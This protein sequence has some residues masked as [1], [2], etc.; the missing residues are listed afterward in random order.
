[1]LAASA[2]SP[3]SAGVQQLHVGVHER[4]HRRLHQ[5]EA[6]VASGAEAAVAVERDHLRCRARR[7]SSAP[8]SLE[9]LSTT[10]SAGARIEVALDRVEQALQVRRGV[11][12]HGDDRERGH[13]GRLGQDRPRLARR[14]L[15]RQLR[16]RLAAGR[17][18]PLAQAGLALQAEQRVGERAGVAGRHPQRAR[19]RAS[20]RTREVRHHRRRAAG[21]RLDRR[22]AEALVARHARQR[23]R[24]R[25]EGLQRLIGHVA[26]HGGL[27]AFQLAAQRARRRRRRARPGA[28]AS[29]RA[30][31]PRR[32]P[33][34]ACAARARRRRARTAAHTRG[35]RGDPAGAPRR[36]PGASAASPRPTAPPGSAPGTGPSG[37]RPRPVPGPDRQITRVALRASARRAREPVPE[38]LVGPEVRRVLERQVVQREHKRDAAGER[39]RRRRGRPGHVAAAGKPVEARPP[40]QGRGAEQH[41]PRQ[42][43]PHE[44]HVRRARTASGSSAPGH[45]HHVLVVRRQLGQ[46]LQ[47]AAQVPGHAAPVR[48]SRAERATVDGDPHRAAAVRPCA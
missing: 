23:E 36:R 18:Q 38:P 46:R 14:P 33:P 24:S 37:P 25:V 7:A 9:P 10:T 30:G 41:P 12:D 39:Q 48:R 40:G 31:A 22:E 43:A 16:H 15:P 6:G 47:Q 8:P 11:V 44:P 1:M 42:P 19:P 26:E 45:Q 5:L 17:H 20:P 2:A 13:A 34:G 35:Q 27:G 29:G 32:G 4:R 3:A 28:R 21:Q